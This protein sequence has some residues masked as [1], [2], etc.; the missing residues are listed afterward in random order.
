M[1]NT[2][3]V[4]MPLSQPWMSSGQQSDVILQIAVHRYDLPVVPDSFDA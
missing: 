3:W 1:K 4:R 2:K